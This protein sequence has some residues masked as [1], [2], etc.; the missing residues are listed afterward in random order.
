M[1]LESYSA[2]KPEPV[3]FGSGRTRFHEFSLWEAKRMNKDGTMFLNTAYASVCVCSVTTYFGASHSGFASAIL[4][5]QII[6]YDA[7]ES[8]KE[9]ESLQTV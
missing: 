1:Q 6:K 3:G 7:H 9:K 5:Y 4:N 8:S 2:E